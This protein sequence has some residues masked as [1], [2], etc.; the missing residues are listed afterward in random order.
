MAMPY[1]LSYIAVLWRRHPEAREIIL[2]HQLQDVFGIPA[3]VSLFAHLF[4]SY[5]CRIADPQ[6]K[7]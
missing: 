1:Q 4:G 2:Q 3:V 6:L 7:V 5:L